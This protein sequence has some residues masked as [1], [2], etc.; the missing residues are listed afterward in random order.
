[1]SHPAKAIGNH[2]I[3]AARRKRA[4]LSATKLQRLTYVAHGWHL[5]LYDAPLLD[6]S[7]EA[8][9]YG[10]VVVSLYHEF[11]ACGSGP[12]HRFATTT[13]DRQGFVIVTPRVHDS[14]LILFMDRIQAVYGRYSATQLSNMAH[15]PG[16]P[17]AR[18][19]TA[20][21]RK[22]PHIDDALIREEF[23]RLMGARP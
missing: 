12:I 11:K 13:D 14:A 22:N 4:L 8:W 3:G 19:W 18:T 10:P 15:A 17:W 9:S 16:T 1:M 5:A 7:V 6:E 21:G 20:S 23:V 2:F